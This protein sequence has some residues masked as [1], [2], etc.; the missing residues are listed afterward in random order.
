[1][2]VLLPERSARRVPRA[3]FQPSLP[4]EQ[5]WHGGAVR[6][7]DPRSGLQ[8]ARGGPGTGTGQTGSEGRSVFVTVHRFRLEVLLVRGPRQQPPLLHE[9][10]P[11]RSPQAPGPARFTPSA[12]DLRPA[13]C[14]RSRKADGWQT[15]DILITGG[16]APP[17]P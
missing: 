15:L 1:M 11:A 17:P 4:R 2:A 8:R 9:R 10:D 12:V 14:L 3:Q 7:V 13:L 16:L 6:D 5:G